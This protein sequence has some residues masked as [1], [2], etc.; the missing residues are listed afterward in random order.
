MKRPVQKGFVSIRL[1]ANPFE[2]DLGVGLIKRGE[3]PIA[4]LF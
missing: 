2:W 1:F 4:A 3:N